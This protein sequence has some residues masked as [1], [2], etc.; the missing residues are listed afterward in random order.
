MKKNNNHLKDLLLK[1]EK[2]DE[3]HVLDEFLQYAEELKEVLKVDAS[4]GIIRLDEF[5]DLEQF[6]KGIVNNRLAKVEQKLAEKDKRRDDSC[7]KEM[8]VEKVFNHYQNTQESPLVAEKISTNNGSSTPFYNMGV[9]VEAT[10]LKSARMDSLRYA[11]PRQLDNYQMIST[12]S[13]V[14]PVLRS[15]PVD[16]GLVGLDWVTF[17]FECERL[18]EQLAY[19]E[20]QDVEFGV[21]DAIETYLDTWL[22]EIFGFGI[23][24]KRPKGMHFYS[25]G[26]DLQDN[27]GIV[28]YGHNTGRVSIQINGTG[29]ALARNGWNERL[30]D[31]LETCKKPKLNRVDLALDD[32]DAQYFNIDLVDEWDNQGGFWCGGCYPEINKL[33]DWKRINGKGRTFTVGNRTSG[34]YFRCY[35]RGKKEGDIFSQWVRA[36]VEFKST[37]RY[38]PLDI[39]L[40]PTSYFKGAY[41]VLERL[42]DKMGDYQA[43]SKPEIIKKQSKINWDKA[44]E[45]TKHQ[46]GKYIRQ[47]RKIYDDYDL[48]NILSSNDDVVPKRLNFSHLAVLH[49]VRN[50]QSIYD[51]Q[52]PDELPLFVG[53]PMVHVSTLH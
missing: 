40:N 36:E 45:I 13:G 16:D 39:L 52:S 44:I 1:I 12:P 37:D 7:I 24:Q 23:G 32:F 33:G 48:L 46:F 5:Q 53:V 4:V 18:G 21:G 25:Y 50:K 3:I 14:V 27:L 29:C 34:K 10:G 6:R 42:I 19:I 35:E 31:F 26:Y 51:F 41:P 2:L 47:F 11:F 22:F 17:S 15:V 8:F 9:T 30:F 43:P 49:S 28:L 20:T 38:I